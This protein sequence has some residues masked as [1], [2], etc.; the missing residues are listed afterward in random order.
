MAWEEVEPDPRGL[1]TMLRCLD[2]IPKVKGIHKRVVSRGMKESDLCL[3]LHV[4][5]MASLSVLLKL[6]VHRVPLG[7][8]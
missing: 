7:C 8:T 5:W 2:F 1:Q 4:Y 3:C 6:N